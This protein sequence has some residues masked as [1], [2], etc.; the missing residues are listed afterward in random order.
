MD[1]PRIKQEVEYDFGINS[2][3]PFVLLTV[4][5]TPFCKSSAF[6]ISVLSN[7]IK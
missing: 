5:Y 6:I 2:K 7:I 3:T 1:G 4:N